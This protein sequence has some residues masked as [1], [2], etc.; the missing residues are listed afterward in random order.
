VQQQAFAAGREE[1]EIRALW[2]EAHQKVLLNELWLAELLSQQRP[3][4]PLATP[5]PVEQSIARVQVVVQSASR[6]RVDWGEALAVPTF[7]GRSRE[8]AQLTEWVVQQRCRV[9]SVLGLGGIGKSALVVSLM[10]LVAPHFEVVLW[11]S[12]RDA[13]SCETLLEDC[14]QVLAP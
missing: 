2:Q 12:L 6:P 5:E 3:S 4:P 10:H 7:Y 8:L 14:L 9:L 13:P 1:E 11:R